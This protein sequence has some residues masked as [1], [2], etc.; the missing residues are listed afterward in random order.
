VQIRLFLKSGMYSCY[1]VSWSQRRQKWY[2]WSLVDD[3]EQWMTELEL[4]TNTLIVKG[5][6]NK[7]VYYENQREV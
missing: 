2:V 6:K 3:S 7:S 5:I 1:V 4:K